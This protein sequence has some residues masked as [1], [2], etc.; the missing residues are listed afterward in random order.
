MPT[1]PPITFDLGFLDQ[2]AKLTLALA[3]IGA[4]LSW[5]LGAGMAFAV[6]LVIAVVVDVALVFMATHRARLGLEQG[7]VDPIASVLMFAGRLVVKAVIL[8]L[9]FL[10]AIP[11]LFW[12]AVVGVVL[13]DLTLA[14]GGSV[15]AIG[16]QMHHTGGAR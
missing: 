15:I 9:A 6:A 16:R 13:F 14:V 3:A 1:N 10:S 8:G 5:T 7:H 11:S 4:V 2:I 12:G